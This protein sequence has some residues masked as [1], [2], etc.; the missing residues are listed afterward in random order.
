MMT[1]PRGRPRAFSPDAA[2]DHMVEMFWTKG[3]AATSLDDIAAATGLQRSSLYAAFG[4]KQAMYLAV[5]ERFAAAMRAAMAVLGGEGPGLQAR[6]R[7]F[8]DRVVDIY[9]SG[10]TPRGCLVFGTAPTEAVTDPVIAARLGALL[11]DLDAALA[12]QFAIA[13]ALG[14]LKPGTDAAAAGR[15]CAAIQ[16]SLSLRA[17]AGTVPEDLRRFADEALGFLPWR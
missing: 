9:T 17:R 14:D 12:A 13:I 10:E 2:L 7:R 16:H 11:A 5:I 6:L 15:A 1:R 4:N 3:Y 8:F